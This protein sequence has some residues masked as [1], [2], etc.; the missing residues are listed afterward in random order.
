MYFKTRR[1]SFRRLMNCGAFIR[2]ECNAKE[3]D[4]GW[5][6]SN[7]NSNIFAFL[8]AA[9]ANTPRDSSFILPSPKLFA[10]MTFSLAR[11][12][13]KNA[14][15][16]EEK[17]TDTTLHLFF[18]R[19]FAKNFETTQQHH[20]SIFCFIPSCRLIPATL[21]IVISRRSTSDRRL[22]FSSVGASRIAFVFPETNLVCGLRI[23]F[24]TRFA[25]L[26]DTP[27]KHCVG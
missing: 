12:Q 24:G 6:T 8:I 15:T 22:W 23:S 20:Q 3:D 5:Y 16:K 9:F 17:E 13:K 27:P 19:R 25:T 7:P 11:K 2:A 4:K 1:Y 14:T 21:S 18:L 10:T 26:F